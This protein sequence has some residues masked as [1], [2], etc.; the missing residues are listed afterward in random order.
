M[1]EGAA[2]LADEVFPELRILVLGAYGHI[3]APISRRLHAA[4]HDV[5]GLGRSV[6]TGVR[7]CPELE[8]IEADIASLREWGSWTSIVCDQDIV[9]NASGALQDGSRDKLLA[10]QAEA[11]VAVIEACER[12]A[13]ER[14]VQISAPGATTTSTT[15]FLRTKALADHRLK[16]S[17]L[18]WVILRPGLVVGPG[19][20][21]GTALLRMLAS[22]PFEPWDRLAQ[23]K[24]QSVAVW[25]LAEVVASACDGKLSGGIDVDVVEPCA[26]SLRE[27]LV[28]FRIWLGVGQRRRTVRIPQWV[29]RGISVIADVLGFLGW[30]SPLRTTALKVLEEGVTGDAAGL[31]AH[32]GSD[33]SSLETALRTMPATLQER[34]FAR[35]YLAMPVMVATLSAFWIATGVVAM[36]SFEDA[37]SQLPASLARSTFAQVV[38]SFGI[39]L[40]VALGAAVLYRPFA[41]TACIG[42]L[43]L[44][45]VYLLGGTAL[46]PELWLDPLGPY[47][48]A[49]PAMVLAWSTTILL[50]E[51]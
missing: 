17:T 27:V 40:D 51:R 39:L 9:V 11:I 15:A 21:G 42:M 31:R 33:L 26:Q 13:V 43:L 12:T 20:Y 22:L 38:V 37:V 16:V 10:V 29:G 35:L 23:S 36:V 34:W 1:A 3:G 19:A 5:T 14:F 18:D 46:R 41:R 7:I 2:L 32:R 47:V 6:R 50:E 8:W 49:L 24:I 44:T 30:R 4:G 45:M 28:Q 25:E 48:K